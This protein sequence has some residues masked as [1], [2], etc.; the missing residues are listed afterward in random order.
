MSDTHGK[1]TEGMECLVTM[2]DITE[3]SYCE[4]QTMPSGKWHPCMF[5]SSVVEELLKTQFKRYLDDV[6][7]AAADCAA[8]VR[9]LVIKGPPTHISDPHGL[10]LP[11]GETHVEKVWFMKEG[12]ERPAALEGAL[13]GAEREE[14]WN[15]QKQTLAAMESAEAAK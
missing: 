15:S 9:R 1:P 4:Y 3:D 14:L 7:K 11:E 2:D 5:T 13:Q 6:E 8:A 12:E 10:P